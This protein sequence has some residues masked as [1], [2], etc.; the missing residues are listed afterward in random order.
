[1]DPP[2]P[3][4]VTYTYFLSD[5]H[6]ACPHLG[7]FIADQQQCDDAAVALGL[8]VT[9]STGPGSVGIQF[10][11]S[12]RENQNK[13][14]FAKHSYL[15]W[16][17]R[18]GGTSSW[19][20]VCVELQHPVA[21][22]WDI[23]YT[24][25]IA[26]ISVRIDLEDALTSA[27]IDTPE[28]CLAAVLDPANGCA[29]DIVLDEEFTYYSWYS[30][31]AGSSTVHY[32]CKCASAGWAD[33]TLQSISSAAYPVWLHRTTYYWREGG[34]CDQPED[35]ILTEER[36]RVASKWFGLLEPPPYMD[37]V[38][39]PESESPSRVGCYDGTD[40]SNP[41][42]TQHYTH[43]VRPKWFA[44]SELTG[45]P[46]WKPLCTTPP[47][48]PPPALWDPGFTNH[49]L[50][51][52]FSVDVYLD[53]GAA[54]LDTQDKCVALAIADARCVDQAIFSGTYKYVSY[55]GSLLVPNT[56][57]DF[58]P[59]CVCGGTCVYA[60]FCDTAGWA[61]H[62]QALL[63]LSSAPGEWPAMLYRTSP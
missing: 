61:E 8:S 63:T 22:V 49:V 13:L 33:K 19:R 35:L 54:D 28:K 30:N 3:P 2:L 37:F 6:G 47:P 27:Q 44:L 57:G 11:C 34:V 42:G 60:P 16:G 46:R 41:S 7:N 55:D 45:S 50:S 14:F 51:G 18:L 23:G 53:H 21:P 32:Y 10:G 20:S 38:Q 4:A 39:D 9:S 26:P 31:T 1:M 58:V 24:N 43:L 25:Y 40:A 15:G 56:A 52:T 59:Y 17:A 62:D 5:L 48:T 36:C 29:S 12:Y